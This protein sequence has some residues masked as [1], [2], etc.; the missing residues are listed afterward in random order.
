MKFYLRKIPQDEILFKENFKWKIYFISIGKQILN[1][2]LCLWDII[3][4][5]ALV[6][7][8]ENNVKK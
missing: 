7:S 3:Y 1:S 8:A 2:E 5:V 4:E 6:I